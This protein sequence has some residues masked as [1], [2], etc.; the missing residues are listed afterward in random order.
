[1]NLIECPRVIVDMCCGSGNL[2]LALKHSFPD[3]AVHG[4]DA[5]AD[6]LNLA[7]ENGVRT[8]LDVAWWLGDLLGALPSCLRGT[9]DLLVANPPYVTVAEYQ[10][11]PA[12]VRDHEPREALV[13]GPLGTEV[14]IAIG[15][16]AASWLAPG[17]VVVCEIGEQQGDS[18]RAAFR[19][20]QP[21]VRRDLAGRDRFVVGR[22]GATS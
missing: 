3:A 18:A 22:R 14:I 4:C 1:L 20:M 6:A 5:S 2:A 19:E 12:D 15:S 11:L 13:A 21:E 9:I 17:G 8:D 7:R 10:T 16:E